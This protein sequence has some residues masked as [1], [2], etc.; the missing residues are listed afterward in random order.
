MKVQKE[1]E[2]FNTKLFSVFQGGRQTCQKGQRK[3]EDST[4]IIL[5]PPTRQI[6]LVSSVTSTFLNG[7][8]GPK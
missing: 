5:A 2:T 7:S 1:A 6:A 4:V 8:I 3:K